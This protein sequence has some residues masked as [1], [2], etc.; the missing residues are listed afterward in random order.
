[1]DGRSQTGLV[2]CASIEDYENQ[3]IKKHENTR[4]DKEVDR[5]THVDTCGAQTGPIFL[6]YRSE[7][8]INDIVERVKKESPLYDFTAVDG[9]THQGIQSRQGG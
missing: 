2:A 4:E 6:A 3:V 9:I 8:V 7:Q 5:I 1:M